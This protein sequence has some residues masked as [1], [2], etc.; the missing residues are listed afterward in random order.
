HRAGKIETNA[1][2]H[3]RENASS[4]FN[5]ASTLTLWKLLRITIRRAAPVPRGYLPDKSNSKTSTVRKPGPMRVV[6]PA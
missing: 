2:L 1:T 4:F 3:T 6:I 5:G